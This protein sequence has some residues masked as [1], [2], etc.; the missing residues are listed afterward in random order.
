MK[1]VNWTSLFAGSVVIIA[2]AS[3]A[4]T[5]NKQEQPA[6]P[7]V[8]KAGSAPVPVSLSQE[9]ETVLLVRWQDVEKAQLALQN[10]V[11]SI[12]VNR[13][14]GKDYYYDYQSRKFMHTTQEP[15]KAEKK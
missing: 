8:A 9:E 14:W 2:L 10:A 6:A 5:Q 1:I 12:Q 4:F 7:P 13:G 15:A 3:P 11:L